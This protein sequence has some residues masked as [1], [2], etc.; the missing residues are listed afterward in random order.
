MDADQELGSLLL[1]GYNGVLALWGL[2]AAGG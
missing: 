2:C 1:C